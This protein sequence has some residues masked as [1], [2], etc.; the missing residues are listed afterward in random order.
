MSLTKKTNWDDYYKQPSS[1]SGFTRKISQNKIINLI[2][3]HKLP[4]EASICEL[5]GAN[6]CFAERICQ[7]LSVENY[8]I[9]DLNSYRFITYK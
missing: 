8:H 5:G 1:L 3:A 9:E 7:S 2:K 6:S 4:N